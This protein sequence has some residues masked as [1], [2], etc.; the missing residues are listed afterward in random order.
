MKRILVTG[1]LGMFLLGS[2]MAA[3]TFKFTFTDVQ[4]PDG[5][6][7]TIFASVRTT[8]KGAVTVCG[9]NSNPNDQFLGEFQGNDNTS[10]DAVD[11]ENYC[12]AHYE[13]SVNK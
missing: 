2:A 11:V 7:G 13:E 12:L 9:F 6:M 8:K 1:I 4:F 10:T 5:R 3:N